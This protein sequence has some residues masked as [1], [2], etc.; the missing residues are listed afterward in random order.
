MSFKN[1]NTDKEGEK[2][3]FSEVKTSKNFLMPMAYQ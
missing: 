3:D 1:K 2:R